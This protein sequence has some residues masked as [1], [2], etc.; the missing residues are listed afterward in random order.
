MSRSSTGDPARASKSKKSI[1]AAR[2]ASAPPDEI[3]ESAES[4]V[5]IAFLDIA[6]DLKKQ[7]WMDVQSSMRFPTRGLTEI[8]AIT[9]GPILAVSMLQ[10]LRLSVA[11]PGGAFGS[12]GSGIIA[13]C[14]GCWGMGCGGGI[15]GGATRGS[16][17]GGSGAA[18]CPRRRP[19]LT[20][21]A[22]IAGAG[23]AAAAA[24]AIAGTPCGFASGLAGEE[25]LP[26]IQLNMSS[27]SLPINALWTEYVQSQ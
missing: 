8:F 3:S 26:F 18:G 27:Q 25:G 5:L 20:G 22:G 7:F 2:Y 21:I 10:A 11:E 14:W 1:R 16:P 24:G 13:T 23:A 12:A 9:S 17:T 6:V 15:A 19:G 4:F